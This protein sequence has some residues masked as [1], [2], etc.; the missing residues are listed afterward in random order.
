MVAVVTGPS[1]GLA[2]HGLARLCARELAAHGAESALIARDNAA[3][4]AGVVASRLEFPFADRSSEDKEQSG[5]TPNSMSVTS[6]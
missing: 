6:G 1:R 2:S 3:L 5:I 4:A